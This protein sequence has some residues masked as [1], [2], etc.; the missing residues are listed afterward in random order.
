M[1]S[2][3]PIVDQE[4]FFAGKCSLVTD[5]HVTIPS[6]DILLF[7]W[8]ARGHYQVHKIPSKNKRFSLFPQHP[9]R[10][11][12]PTG[13][14]AHKSPGERGSKR[15]KGIIMQTNYHLEVHFIITFIIW[16]IFLQ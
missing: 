11:C 12:G 5:I 15:H 6:Q 1:K 7:F 3:L 4:F 9:D 2:P 13:S 8:H 14:P 10:Q 16:N